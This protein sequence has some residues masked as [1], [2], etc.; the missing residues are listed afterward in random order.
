MGIFSGTSFNDFRELR[1]KTAL[2]RVIG[3][4]DPTSIADEVI[5]DYR[6]GEISVDWPTLR[7]EAVGTDIYVKVDIAGDPS[8][9]TLRVTTN[10]DPLPNCSLL[11]KGEVSPVMFA[12]EADA[13]TYELVWRYGLNQLLNTILNAAMS[14][15]TIAQ[16]HVNF[17]NDGVRL[18]NQTLEA[19]VR[20]TVRV[21]LLAFADARKV[22]EALQERLNPAA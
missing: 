15:R 13:I 19:K 8:L 5:E 22:A 4:N 21:R 14:A 10:N 18:F 3:S 11:P 16:Q 6:L 17:C 20:E 9:F 2:D 7:T 12:D 1:L